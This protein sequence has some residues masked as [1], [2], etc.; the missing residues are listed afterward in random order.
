M[1][2]ANHL[3]R[4]IGV[5]DDQR[6]GASATQE[7][8]MKSLVTLALLLVGGVAHAE[9]R[10]FVVLF[11]ADGPSGDARLSHSFGVFAAARF[12]PAKAEPVEISTFCI[13][14]MP[15]SGTIRLLAPPEPGRNYTVAESFAWAQRQGL[16]TSV[17]GPFEIKKEL[18]DLARAQYER[19][20][21]GA[22]AYKCLDR[23]HRPEVAINCI[24]ALADLAPGP[25]VMTGAARGNSATALV[26]RLYQP[27][28]VQSEREHRWLTQ[29][30]LDDERRAADSTQNQAAPKV[31][32]IP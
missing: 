4:E 1:Q 25:Q 24:H 30:L 29:R 28:V 7:S 21:S 20:E 14:W 26:V 10:Y 22:V 31:P 9:E 2:I 23:R 16:R 5:P 8:M 15:A 11:A 13:S 3:H 18:H 6:I 19:L 12:E 32:A 27:Y 17:H